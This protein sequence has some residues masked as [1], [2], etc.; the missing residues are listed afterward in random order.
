MK[1]VLHSALAVMLACSGVVFRTTVAPSGDANGDDTVDVLDVQC[2]VAALLAEGGR[3]DSADVNRDGRV[4][5]LDYQAIIASAHGGEGNAPPEG[6][7]PVQAAG[8]HLAK[9]TFALTG[10]S[11]AALHPPALFAR[12][13]RTGERNSGN[14]LSL[15]RLCRYQLCLTPHAPPHP[16]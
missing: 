8:S 6:P 12:P 4:D 16:C 7:A 11:R 14:A 13:G 10:A 15:S 3:P 5:V 1:R 2:V 9:T